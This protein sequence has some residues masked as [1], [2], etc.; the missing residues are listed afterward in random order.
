MSKHQFWHQVQRLRFTTV[1]VIELLLVSIG[2]TWLTTVHGW[3]LFVTPPGVTPQGMAVT[4]DGVELRVEGHRTD[5][6]QEPLVPTPGNIYQVVTVRLA[7]HRNEA[8]QIIPLL[9][10]RLKDQVGRVYDVQSIPS[11]PTQVAG[12]LLPGDVL[13]EDLAFETPN[14]VSHLTL[15]YEPGIEAQHVARIRLQ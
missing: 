3:R 5:M 15:Y 1:V 8:V 7:N 14:T 12:P 10:F 2:A 9:H 4:T 13:Q 11:L 6:G